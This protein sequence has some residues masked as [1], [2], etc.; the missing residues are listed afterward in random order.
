MTRFLG[1]KVWKV[2]EKTFSNP[3]KNS[4]EKEKGKKKV[5]RVL[6][7]KLFALHAN[8]MKAFSKQTTK[9]FVILHLQSLLHSLTVSL[10]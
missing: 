4:E 2:S 5:A 9:H 10:S 6:V 3:S 8:A 1:N 7:T